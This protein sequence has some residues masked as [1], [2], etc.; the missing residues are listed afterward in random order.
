MISRVRSL[1][2]PEGRTR[3][4]YITVAGYSAVGKKTL[5]RKLY[6]DELDERFGLS[7]TR[8][9]YGWAFEPLEGIFE[10][11]ADHVIYQWQVATDEIIDQL[12]E[13][14][15]DAGHR[16]ILIWRPWHENL[17]DWVA[18]YGDSTTDEPSEANIKDWWLEVIVP[19][20]RND[21]QARGVPVEIVNA[22]T[23]GYDRIDWESVYRWI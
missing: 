7:G 4:E 22:A 14:F 21:L 20:F 10:A 17:R 5:I 8:D 12:A 15:P 1:L 19:R 23:P 2:R 11:T 16:V 13:R 18:V 3:R 9:A 6:T